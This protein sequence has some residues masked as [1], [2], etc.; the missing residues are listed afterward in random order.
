[1]IFKGILPLFVF[2]YKFI[3]TFVYMVLL[4]K[5][6]FLLVAFYWDFFGHLQKII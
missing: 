6:A 2:L 1:M 3:I 5:I 4:Q